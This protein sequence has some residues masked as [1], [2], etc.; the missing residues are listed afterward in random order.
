MF[1]FRFQVPGGNAQIVLNG[2]PGKVHFNGYL[3]GG[4]VMEVMFNKYFPLFSG[5]DGYPGFQELDEFIHVHLA[6][7][8]E[9]GL[10]YSFKRIQERC[11]FFSVNVINDPEADCLFQVSRE[12]VYGQFCSSFPDVQQY[13]VHDLFCVICIVELIIG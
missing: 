13:I 6:V 4:E 12:E 5:Q 7:C 3:L 8:F 11:A 1:E 9:R 10:E 2:F